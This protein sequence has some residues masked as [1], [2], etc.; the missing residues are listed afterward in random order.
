MSLTDSL[1]K[2]Y[3]LVDDAS[4]RWKYLEEVRASG[5]KLDH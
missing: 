3:S 5:R 4:G 2:A 1:L